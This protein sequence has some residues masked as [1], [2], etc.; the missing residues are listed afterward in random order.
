MIWSLIL[1]TILSSIG[2]LA[3]VTGSFSIQGLGLK[4]LCMGDVNGDGYDDLLY[5]ARLFSTSY[6]V[7]WI[8]FGGVCFDNIPDAELTYSPPYYGNFGYA[9]WACDLNTRT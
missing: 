3:T 2:N 8:L 1:L 4:A 5:T 9:I 7:V 6:P